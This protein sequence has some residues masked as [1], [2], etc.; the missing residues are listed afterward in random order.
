M[1]EEVLSAGTLEKAFKKTFNQV[2][3]QW[4]HLQE[5]KYTSASI[6][7]ASV[8][9]WS[10]SSCQLKA[11]SSQIRFQRR[12]CYC[13]NP[14]FVLKPHISHSHSHPPPPPLS[15]FGENLKTYEGNWPGPSS[16]SRLAAAALTPLPDLKRCE[17]VHVGQFLVPLIEAC[18]LLSYGY[19]KLKSCFHGPDGCFKICNRFSVTQII[20]VKKREKKTTGK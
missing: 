3:L 15:I 11:Y 16:A 14:V 8:S 12:S 5:C 1:H 4:I 20:D 6:R 13:I 7:G 18:S 19:H 2:W 17:S 9:A 10:K